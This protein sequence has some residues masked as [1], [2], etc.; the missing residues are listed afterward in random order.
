VRLI[1]EA[2]SKVDSRLKLS[3]YKFRVKKSVF[4]GYVIKLGKMSIDLEKI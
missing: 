2:L 4:L 1:L 3:K